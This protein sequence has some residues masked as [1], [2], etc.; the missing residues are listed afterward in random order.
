MMGWNY[1]NMMGFGG[2]WWWHL[3]GMI[4]WLLL[5]VGVVYAVVRVAGAG[6][7]KL[8]VSEEPLNILKSRY[9]K[10]EIDTEEFNLRRKELGYK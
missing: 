3:I 4:V 5:L 6:T 9:A 2:S 8:E 1:Y 7:R 10:G